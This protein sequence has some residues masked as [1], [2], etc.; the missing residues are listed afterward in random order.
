MKNNSSGGEELPVPTLIWTFTQKR[1]NL[2]W[3]LGVIVAQQNPHFTSINKPITALAILFYTFTFTF[4]ITTATIFTWTNLI[5]LH[6]PNSIV[7]HKSQTQSLSSQ[8]NPPLHINKIRVFQ[9]K[10]HTNTIFYSLFIAAID[11]S[12][13]SSHRV[14][15]LI[16]KGIK[17]IILI[18][19]KNTTRS[20]H[21]ILNNK[22]VVTDFTE[23]FGNSNEP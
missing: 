17:F 12:E 20:E 13:S 9:L 6:P 8:L 18:L 10:P 14:P 11:G 5:P 4:T 16:S 3:I 23:S 21:D 15:A 2:L 19:K 1:K 7:N 22:N